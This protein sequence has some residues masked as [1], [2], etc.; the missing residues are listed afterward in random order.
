MTPAIWYVAAGS[1]AGGVARFVLTG[2]LQQRLAP[3]AQ[4]PLGTL[5]VNVSGSLL[6]GFLLRWLLEMPAVSPEVRLTL[7]VGFCGGFTTFSTFSHDMVALLDHG[8]W[9]RA[10]LYMG[11]SVGLSLAA[12]VAGIALAREMVAWQQGG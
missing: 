2:A 4:F 6:L 7:T 5:I 3:A 8:D 12:T 10:A 11:L 9:R 1:A